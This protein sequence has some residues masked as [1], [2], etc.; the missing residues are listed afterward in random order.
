MFLNIFVDIFK[1]TALI[2]GDLFP[3]LITRIYTNYFNSSFR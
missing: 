2:F 1:L 3:P